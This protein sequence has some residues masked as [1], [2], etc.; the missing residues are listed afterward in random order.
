MTISLKFNLLQIW[1]FVSHLKFSSNTRSWLYVCLMLGN[2]LRHWPNIYQHDCISNFKNCFIC[3][4]AFQRGIL[5][6]AL[7]SFTSHG[8]KRL[9]YDPL[10]NN[11]T[12][13]YWENAGDIYVK[14]LTT[15]QQTRHV[16]TMTFWPNV[17]DA[18]PTLKRHYFNVSCLLG[19]RL[20]IPYISRKHHS[21]SVLSRLPGQ[22]HKKRWSNIKPILDQHLALLEY[23]INDNCCLDSCNCDK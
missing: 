6:S 9:R 16:E 19:W 17:C 23:I 5:V 8:G 4:S 11:P 21:P 15:F 22:Y 3:I 20:Y 10:M 12:L 18:G 7:G 14:D 13:Y 1:Q 2:S